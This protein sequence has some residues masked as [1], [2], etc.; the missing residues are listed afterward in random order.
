MDIKDM[1]DEILD[2]ELRKV[3]VGKEE[4]KKLT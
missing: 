3:V 2:N 4:K 1:N